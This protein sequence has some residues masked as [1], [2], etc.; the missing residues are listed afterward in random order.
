MS[1]LLTIAELSRDRM[2]HL[3][4]AARAYAGGRGRRHPEALVALAFFEESLRTR[5][6]FDAAAAR[7]GARTT[8]I[9]ALKHTAAMGQPETLEDTLRSVEAWCD[10]VCL[11]HPDRE[12]MARAIAATSAPVVNC[13]NG[14]DEHPTQALLDLLTIEAEL[15][16]I[17]GI[18]LALVGDLHAS[19][20]AR[21]LALALAQFSDV[22]IRCIHPPGLE[23]ADDVLAALAAGRGHRVEHRTV[24]DVDGCDAVYV[25]GLPADTR[26]GT[27]TVQQQTALHV[28]VDVA[29]RLRD[30][31][32]VMCPLPRV[33][34]I[35]RAVDEMPAAAYFRNGPL[36][37]AMRMAVLDAVL[38]R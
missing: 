31:G 35:D 18:R 13:G 11:R 6:G 29:R 19:R 36:A 37:L 24:M 22:T 2:E 10:V 25:A 28:T 32:I 21:S 15:G 26:A 9:D 23:P 1:G 17:D 16:R 33:D 8:T 20:C 34:E 27:L 38:S 12:A 3:L 5:V 14:H 7:L 4:A 30:G